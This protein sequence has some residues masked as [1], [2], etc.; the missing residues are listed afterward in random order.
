MPKPSSATPPSSS[1]SSSASAKT[2]KR[3]KSQASASAMS[4]AASSSSIHIVELDISDDTTPVPPA[5][6][7]EPPLAA[8][9]DISPFDQRLALNDD[10][11]LRNPLL[12]VHHSSVYTSVLS[13]IVDLGATFLSAATKGQ[14]LAVEQ[15][16]HRLHKSNEALEAEATRLEALGARDSTV[17]DSDAASTALEEGKT[18]YV[19]T[20]GEEERQQREREGGEEEVVDDE[21]EVEEQVED[22]DDDEDNDE[23]DDDDIEEFVEDEQDEQEVDDDE[24]EDDDHVEIIGD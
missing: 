5:A 21:D 8:P 3:R 22:D 17:C 16:Y 18:A 13:R 4:D 24:D 20:G 15:E 7:P 2:K 12:V 9:L 23:H 14:A 6:S 11:R 19:E 10:P 1:S